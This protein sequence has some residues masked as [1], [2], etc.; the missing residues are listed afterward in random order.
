MY[1][2][3]YSVYMLYNTYT[4]IHIWYCIF[5]FESCFY[6]LTADIR[7]FPHFMNI[8]CEHFSLLV[9][10]WFCHMV[11]FPQHSVIA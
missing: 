7:E 5:C 10:P 6:H 11:S 9:I 1:M 2:H 4:H 8:F 3:I